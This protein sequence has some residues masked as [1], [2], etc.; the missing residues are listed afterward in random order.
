MRSGYCTINVNMTDCVE[1]PE[2]AVTITW[3]VPTGVPVGPVEE[4]PPPQPVAAMTMTRTKDQIRQAQAGARFLS[5][6]VARTKT[7]I[8]PIR[9]MRLTTRK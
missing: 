4:L 6:C 7:K 3:D 8:S 5:A 1:L 9:K 2:V